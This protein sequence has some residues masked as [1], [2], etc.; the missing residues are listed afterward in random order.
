MCKETKEKS[1]FLRFY[2]DETKEDVAHKR[3][4]VQQRM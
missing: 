2:E 3:I 4:H 1:S